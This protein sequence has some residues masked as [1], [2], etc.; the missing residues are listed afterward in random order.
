M[1][2]LVL[3]LALIAGGV[4][5]QTP[6]YSPKWRLLL[7]DAQGGLHSIDM[8]SV[9]LTDHKVTAVVQSLYDPV[10]ILGGKDVTRILS[11]NEVNCVTGESVIRHDVSH[12]NDT[13]VGVDLLADE[14]KFTHPKQ[15]SIHWLI[16]KNVCRK[17]VSV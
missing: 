5:A 13:V 8:N 17:R 9:K 12:N 14:D 16:L 15:G 3:V 4:C 11:F 10:A 2:H 6:Q 7:D 1:R